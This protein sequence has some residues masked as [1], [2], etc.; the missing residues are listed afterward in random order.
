MANRNNRFTNPEAAAKNR[1]QPPSQIL[2]FFNCPPNITESELTEVSV[3]NTENITL[4]HLFIKYE[5]IKTK[6][7]FWKVCFKI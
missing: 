6:I 3:K 1:I 4:H 5:Y 2:H 7:S